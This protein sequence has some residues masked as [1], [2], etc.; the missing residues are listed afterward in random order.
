MS[1]R[2][3]IMKKLGKGCLIV[4]GVFFMLAVIGAVLRG[5]TSSTITAQPT[6]AA[7]TGAAQP[8]TNPAPTAAPAATAGPT[9]FALGQDVQVD[10]VRWNVQEATDLGNT[11]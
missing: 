8:V 5:G 9:T 6:A 11:L 2:R 3:G 1:H 10:E 7:I 4:V